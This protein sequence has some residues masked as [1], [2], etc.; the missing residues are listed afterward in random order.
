MA[1]KPKADEAADHDDAAPG[2]AADDENPKPPKAKATAKDDV[3]SA[4]VV[5]DEADD[6]N[7]KPP[8]AKAKSKDDVA[9][10]P[11]VAKTGKPAA[12]AKSPYSKPDDAHGVP[13]DHADPKLA[14][15]VAHGA[16]KGEIV[17]VGLFLLALTI[18]ELVVVYLP[19]PKRAIV[20][21]LVG[22]ALAKAYTVAM[23]YMHLKGETKIMKYMVYVPMAAP[24]VYAIVLMFEAAFRYPA[25]QDL[26]NMRRALCEHQ[27]DVAACEAEVDEVVSK[28]DGGKCSEVAQTRSNSQLP[29]KT[30]GEGGE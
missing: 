28:N 14:H 6:E 20:I 21:A 7:P 25:C 26:W 10:A 4:K 15:Q 24:A 30:E 19:I 12:K 9:S 2:D 29:T 27:K 23:Y 17:R 1:T 8:K 11:V 22:L 5:D 13:H 16:T 18:V 3:A